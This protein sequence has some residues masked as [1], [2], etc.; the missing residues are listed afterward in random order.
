MR[1]PCLRYWTTKARSVAAVGIC[2]G[3]GGGVVSLRRVQGWEDTCIS[4]PSWIDAWCGC[5]S[6]WSCSGWASF[7]AYVLSPYISSGILSMSALDAQVFVVSFSGNEQV[8]PS[9]PFPSC[10]TKHW[11]WRRQGTVVSDL[12]SMVP[13]KILCEER[14]QSIKN[15]EIFYG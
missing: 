2:Y 4:H 1:S 11:K 8:C 6:V 14:R 13:V 10:S 3:V 5:P 9:L 12:L 7:S 15:L